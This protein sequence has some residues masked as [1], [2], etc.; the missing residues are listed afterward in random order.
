MQWNNNPCFTN[1]KHFSHL[2]IIELIVLYCFLKKVCLSYVLPDRN[3]TAN[4]LLMYGYSFAYTGA[5][6]ESYGELLQ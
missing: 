6:A 5:S 4:Q 3:K 1:L 2:I